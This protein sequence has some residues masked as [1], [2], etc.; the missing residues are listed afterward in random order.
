MEKVDSDAEVGLTARWG[1]T[2]NITIAAAINPDFSQVE[3]DSVQLDINEQYALFF[4]ETRPFF[5]EGADFFKTNV[6]LVHTRTIA[7]PSGALKVT[8]KEGAHTFGLF[9]ARDDVT[10]ILIPG[11]QG[12]EAATFGEVTRSFSDS[13]IPTPSA[14]WP[15]PV[16]LDST[17]TIITLSDIKPS[18]ILLM[19]SAPVPVLRGPAVRPPSY[20]RRSDSSKGCPLFGEKSHAA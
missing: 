8:G 11:S 4:P 3:A 18:S 17:V 1:V 7:D 12:S 16:K 2:P 19:L 5:L 6:N 13:A 14:P 9:S 10:N 15:Q 20:N